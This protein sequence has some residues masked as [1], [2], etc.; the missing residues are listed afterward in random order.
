MSDFT[1]QPLDATE[2]DE[3]EDE[4]DD[5]SA[6]PNS[7]IDYDKI[8][9]NAELYTIGS[10]RLHRSQGKNKNKNKKKEGVCKNKWKERMKKKL[11]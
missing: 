9:S 7:G 1:P 4:N 11:F 2:S 10:Y 8:Q 3:E 6:T 5:D